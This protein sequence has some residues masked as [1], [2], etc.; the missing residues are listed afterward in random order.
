MCQIVGVATPTVC[1]WGFPQLGLD[2]IEVNITDHARQIGLSFST[3]F[4][5]PIKGQFSHSYISCYTHTMARPLRLEFAGALYQIISRGDRRETI[6]RADD[7]RDAWLEILGN[8]YDRYMTVSRAV[9][10][11]EVA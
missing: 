2:G 11:F 9:R 8:V 1:L 10:E 5:N 7:D 6:Y 3:R 4:S